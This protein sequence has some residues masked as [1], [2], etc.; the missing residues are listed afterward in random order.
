M[1]K[2]SV[3][4]DKYCVTERWVDVIPPL[5]LCGLGG[6]GRECGM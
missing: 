3:E 2:L 4:I 1:E 6:E 5:V